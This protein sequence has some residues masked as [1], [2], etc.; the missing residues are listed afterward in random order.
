[1]STP[2]WTLVTTVAVGG[3]AAVWDLR[4]RR[5]PN[6]LSMAGLVAGLLLH[7][8]MAGPRGALLSALGAAVFALPFVLP[9]W[10]GGMG[11]GDVKLALA[12]GAIVAWPAALD[13]LLF[14][15]VSIALW[16]VAFASLRRLRQGMAE[17]ERSQVPPRHPRSLWRMRVPQAPA[18][19]AGAILALVAAGGL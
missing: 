6:R 19:V 2:A 4:T 5:I 16:S 7:L 9:W 11:G 17:R 13:A 15:G 1:M 10:L 14:A 3:A 8:A 12:L 18:L